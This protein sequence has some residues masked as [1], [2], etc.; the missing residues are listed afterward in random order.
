MSYRVLVLVK[1]DEEQPALARAAD[2]ARLMPEIEVVLFRVMR[3]V[4]AVQEAS[5][6]EQ[7]ERELSTLVSHYPSI[8]HYSCK[9]VFAADVAQAVCEYAKEETGNL[10]LAIISANKR[11]TLRDIFVAPIDSKVMHQISIPL[12]VVKDPSA[13]QRLGRAIILATDF[14][15]GAEED[16]V[17]EILFSSAQLFAQHFNGEIHLVN[18]IPPRHGG[19]M[20][21]DTGSSTVLN[22]G[23]RLN[24]NDAHEEE[25]FAFA[26]KHGVPHDNCHVIEGRVDE[27]IPRTC[28][29]LDAR[30][31]CMGTSAKEGAFSTLEQSAS[32]LVLEQIKG[33]ILIVNHNIK[34]AADP[35]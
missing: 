10:D 19:L 30:M 2:F 7:T 25:M 32:E 29:S 21:G 24:R 16:L 13:P 1:P 6:R 15:E 4:A 22:H 34:L 31:V 33:D 20:S 27:M 11:H 28:I 23:K 35:E 17:D 3:P 8:T 12:L 9:V 14:G 26:D 18:C 5:T